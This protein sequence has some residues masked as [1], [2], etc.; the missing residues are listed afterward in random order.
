MGSSF[1]SS[2]NARKYSADVFASYNPLGKCFLDFFGLLSFKEE[3]E[4]HVSWIDV[5]LGQEIEES[6]CEAHS[7]KSHKG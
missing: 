1:F 6:N 3:L 7:C 5:L 2:G 4:G